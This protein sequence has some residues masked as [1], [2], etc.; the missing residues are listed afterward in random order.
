MGLPPEKIRQSEM[1]SM[2]EAV[3]FL[4]AVE[5]PEIS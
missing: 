4:Q 2:D 3:I 5:K 1:K